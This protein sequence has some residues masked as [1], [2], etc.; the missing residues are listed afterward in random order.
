MSSKPPPLILRRFMRGFELSLCELGVIAGKI[1][2]WEND[3]VVISIATQ[4]FKVTNAS[5]EGFVR[6]ACD[7]VFPGTEHDAVVMWC[8]YRPEHDLVAMGLLRKPKEQAA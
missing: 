7:R 2:P 5:I 3:T 8:E 4:S 6:R 1:L